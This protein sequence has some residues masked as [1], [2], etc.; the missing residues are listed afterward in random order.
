MT[1]FEE[2]LPSLACRA[3][4]ELDNAILE[5]LSAFVAVPQLV[6]TLE[7][8]QNDP[9]QLDPGGAVVINRAISNARMNT[10]A[11]T[12]TLQLTAQPG[13]IRERLR[14][15][16]TNPKESKIEPD[17]LKTLRSFRVELSRSPRAYSSSLDEIEPRHPFRR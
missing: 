6:K 10:S 14:A 9:A 5:R 4:V 12:T 16:A 2:G 7:G 11:L 13:E 15:I 8:I 1:S 17:E 3:A